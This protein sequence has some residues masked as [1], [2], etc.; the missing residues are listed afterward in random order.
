MNKYKFFKY[1]FVVVAILFVAELAYFGFIKEKNSSALNV[2]NSPV[3]SVKDIQADPTA[4][5]GTI[6]I[7]G[8]MAA[9]SKD[10]PK[11]FGLIDTAE[12]V[13]CKST[14]CANFYLSVRYEG[15]LPKQWDELKVTGKFVDGGDLFKASKVDVVRHLNL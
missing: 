12:A 6:T 14:G 11:V 5:N 15:K 8:T 2:K 4:F 13:A 3:L 7:I 10:N 9:I 1:L